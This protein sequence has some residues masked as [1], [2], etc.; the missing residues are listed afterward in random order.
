MGNG[1][2][3]YQLIA[4]APLT[5]DAAPGVTPPAASRKWT[6]DTSSLFVQLVDGSSATVTAWSYDGASWAEANGGVGNEANLVAG[7][8]GLITVDSGSVTFLQLTSIA[9][10]PTQCIATPLADAPG[11]FS[12]LAA[13]G[14]GGGL[15]KT[16]I[17]AVATAVGTVTT[18]VGTATTAV[19]AVTTAVGTVLSALRSIRSVVAITPHDTNTITA[20]RQ[21]WIQGAGNIKC[22][23]ADDGATVTLAVIPGVYDWSIILVHTDTTATGI[24]AM[25]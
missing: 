12:R 17:D 13:A 8:P 23:F 5:N 19:T 1:Y 15:L 18:A 6:P 24:F 22:Q 10:S 16:A 14:K 11:L 20:T 2:Q 25:Y 3:S 7:T 9:G 4:G 21:V